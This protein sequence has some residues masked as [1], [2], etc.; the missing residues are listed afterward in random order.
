MLTIVS[1]FPSRTRLQELDLSHNRL[2]SVRQLDSLPSLAK[3]DLGSNQLKQIDVSAPLRMLR[4]L[5]LA[6]NQLETLDVCMFPSLNLLY[7]D[8]NFLS[9]VFGLERCRALEIL[10]VREQKSSN[11][12]NAYLD[13]DLGKVKDIRKVFLSSNK[14]STRALS[15]SAPLLG[16]QLLDAASCNLQ[17][18]P[19]DFSSN[20]PNLKVLNLNFNSLSSITELVGL[21]CLSRLAIAG[22]S[23]V[24]MRK[25]C[26]VLSRMGRTK[27]GQGCSLNK[28]DLR[29]N[30]LTLRFY[31]PALTG[32]GKGADKRRIRAI[33][34]ERKK[35]KGG[36]DLASAL[37][38]VGPHEGDIRPTLWETPAETEPDI[39]DPYTLPT[40]DA[41]ADQKYLSHLDDA[42]R[43]RRRIFEL[44][45]YAGTGGS[46]KLLDGL[47]F[48]PVLTEG[49]D[50]D[51]AWSKLEQLGVLK[52][53]AIT[54]K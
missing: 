26:Q 51:H 12:K 18:L 20:F 16:L 23:I 6:N 31:P 36:L 37:A 34:E 39:D 48:R 33:P 11:Q 8:Q 21:N 28:V 24:R 15:P 38:D 17:T 27:Q 53:K 5:K 50:M 13:I 7:I 29:G 30:P 49:S 35:T 19:A 52:K 46:I 10:S 41:Q 44:M 4:A 9:T 14:L 25:L 42:T 3:L 32:N 2:V 47:E 40:A 43:L 54:Q 1:P 45:L 22:N